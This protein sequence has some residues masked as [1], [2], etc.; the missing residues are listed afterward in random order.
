MKTIDKIYAFIPARGGSKRIPNKN[1]QLIADKPLI[2][3]TI[4]V[5]LKS[6]IF[7]KVIVSTDDL[8]IESLSNDL[9]A[10]VLRRPPELAQDTSTTIDSVL[11]FINEYKL[12]PD[13]III[14]LQP[15][16][17]LRNEIH[18]KEALETFLSGKGSSLVS[19]TNP[20]HPPQWN[21]KVENDY[22]VPL[23][24]ERF[25]FMRS[26]D[27]PETYIP[28]GAIYISRVSTIV[29]KKTFYCKDILPYVMS[30]EDSIDIDE[31][32]DL[33]L[34]EIIIENKDIYG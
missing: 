6:S 30:R 28:N 1:L 34:A 9:D 3:Y 32:L 12:N 31:A 27:L 24:D 19:V 13:D 16:S 15:T 18:V 10:E 2:Q 11:H 23:M 5:A 14:L 22:L 29:N 20:E 33:K 21:F 7:D 8:Q 25:I 26:Q 4:E 17:P